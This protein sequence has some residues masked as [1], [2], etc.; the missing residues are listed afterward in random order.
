M[1]LANACGDGALCA[2]DWDDTFMSHELAKNTYALEFSRPYAQVV[3]PKLMAPPTRTPLGDTVQ[4]AFQEPLPMVLP[5]RTLDHLMMIECFFLATLV[6][7]AN[8]SNRFWCL[9]SNASEDWLKASMRA[10][11]PNAYRLLSFDVLPVSSSPTTVILLHLPGTNR[12]RSAVSYIQTYVGE[13]TRTRHQWLGRTAVISARDAFSKTLPRKTDPMQWKVL[14][15]R[16]LL[17]HFIPPH[18]QRAVSIGDQRTDAQA[19]RVAAS[20]QYPCP[21]AIHEV[22]LITQGSSHDLLS[23][24]KRLFAWWPHLWNTAYAPLAGI[25][26]VKYVPS[27]ASPLSP[28]PE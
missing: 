13:L 25:W 23:V 3:H 9:V 27:S 14:A 22:L 21:I 6:D 1:P 24:W 2:L 8:H 15:W 17:E 16:W 5:S 4:D 11:M 18:L 20:R 10:F 28:P 26:N 19:L 7:V 12:A